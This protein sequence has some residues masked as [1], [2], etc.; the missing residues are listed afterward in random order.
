LPLPFD[1]VEPFFDPDERFAPTE[2][3]FLVDEVRLDAAAA[4]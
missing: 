2:P 3:D 4:R 1:F